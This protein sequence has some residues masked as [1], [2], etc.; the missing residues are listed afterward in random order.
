M[1][2]GVKAV[3]C[4]PITESALYRLQRCAADAVHTDAGRLYMHVV[5]QSVAQPCKDVTRSDLRLT[6]D[7]LPIDHSSRMLDGIVGGIIPCAVMVEAM[8][9]IL[10]VPKVKV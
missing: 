2:L 9:S 6:G 3:N 1:T 5:I 10:A 7:N 4:T 8:E